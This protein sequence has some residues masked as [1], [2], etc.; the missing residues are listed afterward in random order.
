M[1]LS[2]LRSDS[3]A[4]DMDERFLTEVKKE[5]RSAI[6]VNRPREAAFKAWTDPLQLR[7]WWGP[8]GFDAREVTMQPRPGGSF[9]VDMEDAEGRVFANRGEFREVDEP[10]RLVFTTTVIEDMGGGPPLEALNTVEFAEAGGGTEITWRWEAIEPAPNEMVANALA[11]VELSNN[12]SL[13][14]LAEFLSRS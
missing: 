9:R 12:D 1:V 11:G 4:I 5:R 8:R 7:A 2:T 3:K 10:S 6:T 14:R 13:S